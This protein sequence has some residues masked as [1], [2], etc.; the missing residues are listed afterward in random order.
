MI[1]INLTHLDCGHFQC[2]CSASSIHAIMRSSHV[3]E[4]DMYDLITDETRKP[5]KFVRY[6]NGYSDSKCE[7]EEMYSIV[8]EFQTTFDSTSNSMI[9]GK[10][11]TR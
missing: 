8:S 6:H 3:D 10:V 11:F 5:V 2:P 7:S 1:V 4:L 9:C